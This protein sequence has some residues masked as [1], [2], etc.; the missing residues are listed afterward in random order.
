MEKHILIVCAIFALCFVNNADAIKCYKCKSTIDSGCTDA[1]L[2]PNT[3]VRVVDCDAEPKPN[4]MEQYMTVT[5][6][7][8]VV[9]SDKIGKIISRDCHY[10]VV[11]TKDDTCTVS[12]SR[13]I[14]SCYTC[15]GDMCNNTSS[16]GRFMALGMA[17]ILAFVSLHFAF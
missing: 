6:C 16:A 14:D 7:N 13:Q 12:H 9:T 17:A 8:K 1:A 2:E 4:S 11:G 10:Q 15:T 3:A 5:K